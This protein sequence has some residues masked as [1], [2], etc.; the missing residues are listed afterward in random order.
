MATS[1]LGILARS[2]S[3]TARCNKLVQTPVQVYGLAGSYASAL[4]SAASKEKSLDSVEKDLKSVKQLWEK[5]TK[6]KDFFAD[7]T[8]NARR[9]KAAFQS[10]VKK[11]GYSKVTQNLVDTM[12]DNGRLT[13]LTD[14][15]NLYLEIMSAHRGEV[16][17]KVTVAKALDA[18]TSKQL[19]TI[20]EGFLA[21]GQKLY[22][23]TEVDP[24]LVGGMT[25]TIGD[26]F[27]DMSLKSKIKLYTDILK[28][29]AI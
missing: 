19:Q 5:D 9:K 16:I 17:C 23:Q 26:K 25:V 14:V 28:S 27:I 20:L 2:F 22:L 12:A 21:K 4:Y 10:V 1:G 7:P 13:K 8:E 29:A 11:N 15:I 24:S 18:N 6:F 3:T